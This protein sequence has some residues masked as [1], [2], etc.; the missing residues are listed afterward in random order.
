MDA[1]TVWITLDPKSPIIA[2]KFMVNSN[3]EV[4][5]QYVEGYSHRIDAFALDPL[6]LPLSAIPIGLPQQQDGS[7]GVLSDA[8]PEAWGKRVIAQ[9]LRQ[10][11]QAT[12]ATFV[13]W[14]RMAPGNASGCLRFTAEQDPLPV[15]VS[16]LTGKAL[17]SIEQFACRS[18]LPLDEEA[19]ALLW[20][21]A[22]MGGARPKTIVLHDGIE[23]IAKFSLADDAFNMPAAEYATMRLA[24][25]AGINVPD[26]ELIEVAGK[27][28]FLVSRFDRTPGGKRL[29]YL[30]A[31]TLVHI[32]SLSVDRREYQANYS[33]A[34]ILESARS[35]SEQPEAD[36]KELFRRMVFNIL[37][38]NVDD[39]LRNHGYLM[40]LSG[41]YT[42]APAFDLVP[43]PDADELPQS[44]GVGTLG[45]ASTMNN[46]FS[47]CSRFYLEPE[48][49]KIIIGEVREVVSH[50][51]TIF[52]EA[53]L[54]KQ[55]MQKLWFHETA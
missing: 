54:S 32:D 4:Q 50:W 44:I 52:Q 18:D 22:S 33:Y 3:G 11:K 13:D 37:V 1:N 46:A 25:Q 51:Q 34:G 41:R 55:D 16:D 8:G 35:I 10:R 45:A 29:H 31:K 9:V 40:N 24:H 6:R 48:E 39:H 26:F 23:Y 5:L 17:S 47:Q 12:P 27:P 43:H 30:S 36:G 19:I 42:L 28:V 2:A 49:A 21:G 15:Q 7:Y 20:P 14:L 38:G 53:G